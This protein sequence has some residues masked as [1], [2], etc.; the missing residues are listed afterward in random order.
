MTSIL[1]EEEERN[2]QDRAEEYEQ[3]RGR[4][5]IEGAVS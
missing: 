2:S 3:V 4:R 5:E 1:G